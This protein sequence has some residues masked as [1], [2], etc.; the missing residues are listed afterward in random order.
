MIIIIPKLL[1]SNECYLSTVLALITSY[2]QASMLG[3]AD[4]FEQHF[5]LHPEHTKSFKNISK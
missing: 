1:K 4:N 3:F 2:F 5:E